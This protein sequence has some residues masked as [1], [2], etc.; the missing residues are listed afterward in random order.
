MIKPETSFAFAKSFLPPFLAILALLIVRYQVNML[1]FHTL[2]ELFSVVVGVLMMV[3]AWNT[4]RFTENNFLLYIG[5]GYFWVAVLDT[6]HTLT[7]GGLPFLNYTNAEV[8]LHF[9]IYARFFEALLLFTAPL[10]LRRKLNYGRMMFACAALTVLIV[11]AA[12]SLREPVMMT[13]EG[14]SGYKVAAEY[15]IMALLCTA[16]LVYYHYRHQFSND[17]LYYILAA[18]VL[19]VIAEFCFTLYGN[20][21]DVA[22]IVGHLFKF[23]SFWMIYLAIVRTTLAR[24][25]ALLASHSSSYNAIPHA[26]TVVDQEGNIAQLN[27]AAEQFSAAAGKSLLHTPV[28]EHFHSIDVSTF[29]CELCQSIRSGQQLQ[30]FE[31]YLPQK[32]RWY[33]ASLSLIELAGARQGM[34]QVLTD[35]SSRKKVAEALEASE[36]RF[37]QLF[38]HTDAISVQGYDRDR[39]VVYWNPA[40]E[41][42]YG[43][44]KQQ[45]LGQKLEDLIIPP[46]MREQVVTGVND[47]VAGGPDIPSSELVLQRAD[48]SDA[49]VY[50]SHVMVRNTQGEPEMFCID[51][52]ISQSREATL[53]LEGQEKWLSQVLRTLP[54]G[55]QETDTAGVVTYVNEALCEMFELSSQQML[56]CNIWDFNWANGLDG[57]LQSKLQSLLEHEPEPETYITRYIGPQ[58]GQLK[59]LE[60]V[61]DY[62]RDDDEKITGF[63]SVISDITERNRAADAIRESEQRFQDFA[64]TAA[65]MFWEMDEN[66]RF[67]Y[68]SGKVSE[69]TGGNVEEFIGKTREELYAGQAVLDTPEFKQ[70]LK[71]LAAHLPFREYEIKWKLPDGIHYILISGSP[72]FDEHGKFR[73]YRGVTQDI[74]EKK[75]IE[76]K[77]LHQAHFDSLTGLP[78][79]FLSLDRLNHLISDAQRT[80]QMAAVIFLDLDDFKKVNDSLGHEIGDKLLI[81]A[82]R[83]LQQVVRKS[84]TVG[85]LG[86]DEFIVLLGGLN[87]AEDA[88]PF[89]EN[90]LN[91]LRSSFLIEGRELLL[92]GSAGISV[93]PQDGDTPSELLRNADSAMYHAKEAGRNTFSYFTEEMNRQVSRRVEIEE[94]IHGA[95]ARQEFSVYY[96]PKFDVESRQVIGAEA[97]L[98]WNNP[99]I[100]QVSPLEFIP[101]AEQTGLIVPIGQFVLQQSL[102]QAGLWRQ[103]VSQHFSVAVNLSPRQFRDPDLVQHIRLAIEQNDVPSEALELEITEGVLLSGHDY[104]E[105][106]LQGIKSLG[107]SLAMDDFGTGY[108]SLS[109]L[110]KYPFDVLKVDQSFV[111]DITSDPADRALVNAA[112]AMAHSLG[113]NVVAEGVETTEQLQLLEQMQCDY[114]QG[115]LFGKPL[116]ADQFEQGVLKQA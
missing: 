103:T 27:Q 18:L 116:P 25:F 74:T 1:T 10:L 49:H 13:A 108:S 89:T 34:V 3:I 11:W 73:G 45:A 4:Y 7:V 107:V 29:D 115:Y 58:S 53:A 47:W 17:V 102:L 50:S 111:R 56:G 61:W 112:I 2:A 36:H 31:L 75:L 76:E 59:I 104:I 72:R 79:R 57:E 106:A 70:H 82:A 22:F 99:V 26:V 83:R 95:L 35:I 93:Y 39:R 91:Q 77:V 12:I 51:I 87:A 20:F 24:P 97:L 84:D 46:D 94:Q 92:S 88:L 40:S 43:Y 114:L 105:K 30:G 8:T 19:K 96:Q 32:D 78:N 60:F 16:F 63:I 64:E 62:Q 113:L 5:I 109:Y 101:I 38:E 52:D 100:G 71:I 6:W 66:L 44:S 14:L 81:E 42:L 69:L 86:G 15:I 110:R 54:N 90:L 80:R 68:V 98:R 28:H 65:D 9:W 67:S 23:L 37:R 41:V 21:F 33:L 85:R 55:V 48:G